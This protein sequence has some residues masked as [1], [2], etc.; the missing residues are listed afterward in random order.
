MHVTASNLTS[1]GAGIVG[2]SDGCKFKLAEALFCLFHL[3][4]YIYGKQLWSCWDCPL[5]LGKP[6]C[7]NL[8][9]HLNRFITH[10]VIKWLW[11]VDTVQIS[12]GLQIVI[13]LWTW[14]GWDS[15]NGKWL[16][17]EHSI[18]KRLRCFYSPYFC[19]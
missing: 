16:E 14:H 8:P 7:H 5:F 2:E 11:I 13:L 17:R 18:I 1:G 6:P 3:L 9:L 4:L 12:A 10:F 15:S 19:Q